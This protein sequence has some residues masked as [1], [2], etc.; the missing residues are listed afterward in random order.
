MA[1]SSRNL[2]L[3]ALTPPDYGLLEPHLTKIEF[4]LRQTFE[5]ENKPIEYIYFPENGIVSIVAKSRHEQA[6]AAIVGREGMTGIPVVLGN[7]RWVNDTYVQVEG[8]GFRMRSNDLRPALAKS[9]TLR[10]MLLAFTQAFVVQTTQTALANARGN[11]E[12][13]LARWLLMAHDRLDGDE[14]ALTHEFLA[15]MLGVR[16]AGVTTTLQKLESDGLVAAK[17]GLIV[18]E[19]RAGLIRLADRLYGVPEAEYRRLI[20]GNKFGT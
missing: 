3:S 17:R 4:A 10:A 13:R 16:R 6:E 12:G 20:P 5:E 2:L 9:A 1:R 7:D 19:D 15:L 11:V 8:H 18:I 14:V